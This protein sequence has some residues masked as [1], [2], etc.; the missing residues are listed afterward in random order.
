MYQHDVGGTEPPR[1]LTM[2]WLLKRF[3][4]RT[5]YTAVVD[6]AWRNMVSQREALVANT[7]DWDMARGRPSDSFS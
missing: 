1:L 3:A 2:E 7:W 4:A 5:L 6:K